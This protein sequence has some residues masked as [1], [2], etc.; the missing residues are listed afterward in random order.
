MTPGAPEFS[1]FHHE[2]RLI[3]RTGH[4]V[5]LVDVPVRHRYAPLRRCRVGRRKMVRLAASQRCLKR[6]LALRD[7]FV[8]SRSEALVQGLKKLEESRS[9]V[10]ARIEAGRRRV[11]TEA[12]VRG[13][14]SGGSHKNPPTTQD[15]TGGT[16]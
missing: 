9:K 5:V 7:K 13:I 1:I 16:G 4:L 11:Q 6:A 3:G 8:L 2:L 15:N 12:D 14:H 10:A